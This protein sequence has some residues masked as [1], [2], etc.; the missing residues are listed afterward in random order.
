VYLANYELL[1]VL[2][3][4]LYFQPQCSPE[5]VLNIWHKT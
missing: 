3:A 5:S 1:D 2:V 4:S